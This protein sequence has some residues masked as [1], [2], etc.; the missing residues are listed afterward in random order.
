MK[1]A[2]GLDQAKEK[3]WLE[4]YRFHAVSLS[5]LHRELITRI[6]KYTHQAPK[7]PLFFRE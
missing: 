1:G 6:I 7:D 2:R 5:Q 3:A 4:V